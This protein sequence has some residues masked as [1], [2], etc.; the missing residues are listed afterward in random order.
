MI[1]REV[2]KGQPWYWSNQLNMMQELAVLDN[3]SNKHQVLLAE[4]LSKEESINL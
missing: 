4:L 2:L 1:R 3:L